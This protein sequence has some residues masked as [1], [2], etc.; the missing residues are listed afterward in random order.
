MQK[1]EIKAK[2]IEEEEED[3]FAD[4]KVRGNG[5][6]EPEL[7]KPIIV[8]WDFSAVAESALQYAVMFA[9]IL[10]GTIYLLHIVKKR[11]DIEPTK[12]KLEKI[13]NESFDKY[14]I[15]PEVL[16]REG[17]I[18]KTITEIANNNKA[19]LVVMGT[20]GVKGI[21]KL[22]GSWALKVIS[23]TN[24]PFV[25]VQ[26]SPRSKKIENVVF[27][28]DYKKE[29]K[30]KLK[31]ARLLA[32]H[33]DINFILVVAKD[34][35]NDQF[36]K[37]TKTN[38]NYVKGF[39]KQNNISF[40]VVAIGGTDSS[41]EA[42]LKYVAENMPDLIMILTNRNLHIQD[43]MLGVEEQ[44]IIANPQKIPVMVINPRKV[45]YASYS[46]FGNAV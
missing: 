11:K 32:K 20:H 17:N 4:V 23:G 38:L 36:K 16:V 27:P 35:V 5:E 30:Q 1:E 8:P 22:T 19:K 3:V 40:K 21:Q 34:I 15:K 12:A 18:F 25:V 28:I 33:Y 6:P 26:S 41:A 7:D 24:T 37:K 10:G 46:A 39:F 2:E 45:L 29:N 14:K 9:P 13:A 42:T 31:Q 43:Y 44:K